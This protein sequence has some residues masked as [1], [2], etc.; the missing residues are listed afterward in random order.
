MKALVLA[1]GRGTRLRRAQAELQ[2]G[3]LE[4]ELEKLAAEA[5]PEPAGR[6]V[7]GEVRSE[8]DTNSVREAADRLRGRLGRGAAVLALQGGGKLTF[9]AAVTD[10]LVKEKKL[11]ASDLVKQ[12]AQV[13]G[14]SGGGKPHLALAGGKDAT[15]LTAALDEAR[16]LLRQALAS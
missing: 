1:G 2:K 14:G 11:S 16:R 6:W 7:V 13:A 8:A 4:A 12:V 9:L 10:D 5:T 3:G 15:K